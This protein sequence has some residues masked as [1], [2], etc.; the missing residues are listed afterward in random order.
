MKNLRIT[1]KIASS[2]DGRIAL[3]DGTSQWITSSDSRARGHR[4]RAENDAIMVGVGTV[5]ADDPLLTARTVPLPARQPVRIVADS[6][7]RMPLSSRLVQSA[8]LGRVVAVTSREGSDTLAGAGVDVWRCG[9]G[10]RMDI[11]EFV[12][13]AEAEG[14]RTLLIE[15]GSTL[16]ASFIRAGLVDEIAWFRAPILIGGEGLPALGAL[17]L[18]DLKSAT[19][20]RPVATERIGDDVLDTYVRSEQ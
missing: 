2:L 3:S 17:G 4:M 14:L 15:G 8:D 11:R 12:R 13:R 5:L 20:W 9:N 18:S 1:L 10:V 7:G 6:Q 19:R 16:A